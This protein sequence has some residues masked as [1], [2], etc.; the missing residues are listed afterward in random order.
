MLNTIKVA[1][2]ALALALAGVTAHAG[3]IEFHADHSTTVDLD[4]LKGVHSSAVDAAMDGSNTSVGA[5]DA[6][7]VK[8]ANKR[9]TT[10]T[11]VKVSAPTAVVAGALGN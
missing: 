3:G 11:N 6:A 2:V 1:T 9:I 4:N 7:G 5:G 10:S 8:V